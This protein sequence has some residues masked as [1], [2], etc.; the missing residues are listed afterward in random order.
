MTYD[1]WQCAF[2]D[3]NGV[4]CRVL[5]D[6][7]SSKNK[8]KLYCNSHRELISKR[9]ARERYLRWK[10]RQAGSN[11]Q[12]ADNQLASCFQSQKKGTNILVAEESS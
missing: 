7:I 1:Q 8:K 4:Q 11:A 5:L 9:L 6:N 3:T 12:N 2:V 10:A